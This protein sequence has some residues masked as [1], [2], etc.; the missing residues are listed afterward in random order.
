MPDELRVLLAWHDGQSDECIGRFAENWLLLS[1]EQI[2]TAR[3]ELGIDGWVPFL[4][5]DAGNYVCIDTTQAGHP[6]REYW[7][8]NSQH[9]VVAPSLTAWMEAFV[10]DVEK[11][12]YTED[13]E[14]GSFLKGG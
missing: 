2:A 14:R 7:A 12:K 8:G 5:D 3:R 13:P 1:A 11:G 4:D 6:V 10:A 9:P